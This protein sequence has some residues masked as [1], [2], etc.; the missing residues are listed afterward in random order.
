VANT[1][2]LADTEGL[3]AAE[4]LPATDGLGRGP[5]WSGAPA[6]RPLEKAGLR[7]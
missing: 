2:G 5:I 7:K 1:P 3:P 4:G 6:A